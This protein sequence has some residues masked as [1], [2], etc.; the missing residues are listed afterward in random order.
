M[1]SRVT[2]LA[3]GVLLSAGSTVAVPPDVL[4]LYDVPTNS[5]VNWVGNLHAKQ[6]ANLIGHFD[7]TW[8]IK[9]VEEYA[10]G[11]LDQSRATFYLGTQYRGDASLP[12]AFTAE[13]LTTT[14]T[15]CWC[16]YN[17][18]LVSW[19]GPEFAAKFGFNFATLDASGY[20]NVVYK[21][22]T[23]FKDQLDPELG[24]VTI[25]D[26]NQAQV[27][28]SAWKTNEFDA[29]ISI[30]YIIHSSNF[31][32]CADSP[33]DYISEENRYVVFA[34]VLHDI[35]GIDH[36]ESH[37]AI[38]RLEDVTM[39]VYPTNLLSSLVE[40]LH[41]LDV[42]FGMAFIPVYNDPFGV[43]NSG[44]PE[45]HHISDN[46]DP[47]AV[48]F[49]EILNHAVTNGGQLLIHG[50][51]HQYDTTN[52]P[53]SGVTAE[54][55]EFWRET[56]TTNGA[57][58]LYEP[59]PEDSP[60]WALGRVTAATNELTQAGLPWVGWETPHYAASTVDY[61]VFAEQFLLTMQ[62]LLCFADDFNSTNRHVTGQFVPYVIEHDIYGQRVIPENLGYFAPV[63]SGP[64]DGRPAVDII[65]TARKNLAVRDGWANC[66]YHGYYGITNLQDIVNGIRALGYTYVPI[67]PY[68][69][70]SA[71]NLD[72]Q[73]VADSNMV[74]IACPTLVGQAYELE[75]NSVISPDSWQMLTN[76]TGTG[77]DFIMDVLTDE[78]IR[79]FRVRLP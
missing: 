62:R 65:R 4:I 13:T 5:S 40:T 38:I 24:S 71:P 49:R 29:G 25:T 72:I 32:Y 28:V 68:G 7:L 54:D 48:T 20:S 69:L 17:L 75:V 76:F 27:V 10:A 37:H 12:A 59:I 39:R 56:F 50:Y 36:A 46:A 15:L 2:R 78:P 52:N 45:T 74:R 18:W 77:S 41:T 21:G 8:Q 51:T 14:N 66:F 64:Y 19:T 61:P 70:P 16:K 79:Y 34:D 47:L 6:L 23:F 67:A 9:P 35:L 1:K 3:F 22:E 63:A 53:T 31:W 55:F 43:Y 44:T 30:P 58:N 57:L 33:F 60:A 26:S 73:L 11:D 42:P